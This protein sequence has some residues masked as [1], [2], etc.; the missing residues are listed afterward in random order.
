MHQWK[1]HV[2]PAL[3]RSLP[4]YGQWLFSSL[5]VH[6]LSV[7]YYECRYYWMSDRKGQATQL[8]FADPTRM[9]S[10]IYWLENSTVNSTGWEFWDVLGYL[11]TDWVGAFGSVDLV[12]DVQPWSQ[13]YFGVGLKPPLI[14]LNSSSEVML[15]TLIKLTV[16]D[17]L[18]ADSVIWILWK[19]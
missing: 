6:M 7:I 16:Q 14:I 13:V 3:P 1:E 9:Q 4:A 17:F 10:V 5:C 11:D 2:H 18:M 15:R 12:I 8:G 19:V